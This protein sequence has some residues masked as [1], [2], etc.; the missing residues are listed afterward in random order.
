MADK[1]PSSYVM[2]NTSEEAD[3]LG[4]QAALYDRHTEYL[5]RTAG[6]REGM[7]VLDIGCGT[8]EV[9]LAAARVVGSSGRVLGVDMDPGSWNARARMRPRPPSGMSPS[10]RE[11]S[12]ISKSPSPL[13]LLWDD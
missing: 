11:R 9:S 3:R 7:R 4:I 6:L 5:L 13:T 12:P 1:D 2:G 8:G 10:S